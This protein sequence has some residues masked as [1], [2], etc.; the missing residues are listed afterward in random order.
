MGDAFLSRW[1]LTHENRENVS[2]GE[3]RMSDEFNIGFL[4]RLNRLN[5]STTSSSGYR[6]HRLIATCSLRQNDYL[7]ESFS[8][9]VKFMFFELC[10]VFDI[11]NIA[12][13]IV[14]S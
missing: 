2:R 11:D 4:M 9:N 13:R 14:T 8:L 3:F 12:R 6:F 10:A 1:C 5:N 7:I